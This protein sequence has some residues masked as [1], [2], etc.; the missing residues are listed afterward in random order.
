MVSSS[1]F[2]AF[3]IGGS[4]GALEVISAVL[5]ALPKGLGVAVLIVV[6]LAPNR[7]SYLPEVLATRT[8]LTVKEPDDK[9]PLLPGV[10]YVAPANYHLL[11]ERDRTLALSVDDAVNFSRPSIDVLFESA[12]DSLGPAVAGVLLT[13]ANDDGA[14]G[15]AKIKARGG[16]AI[17]QAPET[18]SAAAMPQ[19]GIRATAVDHVLR[20]EGIG[21]LLAELATQCGG[22]R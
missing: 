11:V 2:E 19:A 20:P 8:S 4:A 17:V 9:E 6:H 7:H 10:V 1:P 5:P 14:S 21:P 16:V 15:L 18:A 12:A 22:V 13:G 3:V